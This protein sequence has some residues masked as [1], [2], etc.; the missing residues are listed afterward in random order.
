MKSSIHSPLTFLSPSVAFATVVEAPGLNLDCLAMV[1]YA[2]VVPQQ[3]AL[4]KD[5][6]SVKSTAGKQKTK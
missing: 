6:M 2:G 1:L 5:Q 3:C 4:F